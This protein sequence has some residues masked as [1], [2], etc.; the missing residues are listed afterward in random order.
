MQG[1]VNIIYET[2]TM[3][4]ALGKQQFINVRACTHNFAIYLPRSLNAHHNN[5]CLFLVF[6]CATV[7]FVNGFKISVEETSTKSVLLYSD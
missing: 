2:L 1:V 6:T 4:P 5:G 3:L 7:P